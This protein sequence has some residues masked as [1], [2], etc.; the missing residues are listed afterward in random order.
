MITY[1]VCNEFFCEQLLCWVICQSKPKR[2]FPWLSDWV[3]VWIKVKMFIEKLKSEE[4]HVQR[5]SPYWKKYYY[6]YQRRYN[7][8]GGPYSRF[9]TD[10]LFSKVKSL[11]GNTCATLFSNRQGFIKLYPMSA[12]SQAHETFSMFIHEVGIPHELHADGAGELIQGEFRKK[13]NKYEVYTTV[14]EPY[15]PWQNDAERKIKAVKVLGRYL[16]QTT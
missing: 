12:K 5:S 8:L 9:Y 16:M 11:S 15:S 7:R 14:T 2:L 10:V 3:I 1:L 4:M 6:T 13:L